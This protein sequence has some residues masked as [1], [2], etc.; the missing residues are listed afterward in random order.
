MNHAWISHAA[1][2]RLDRVRVVSALDN[3]WEGLNT[4]LNVSP[5]KYLK[6]LS[7]FTHMCVCRY[8]YLSTILQH[9]IDNNLTIGH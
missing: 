4:L 1:M 7:F 8:L 2:N 6:P 5:N 3:A 9:V